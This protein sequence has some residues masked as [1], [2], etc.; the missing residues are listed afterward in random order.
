MILT[1]TLNPAIDLTYTLPAITLG[2]SHRVPEP[3]Q[4]AGGKGV[5]VARVL[6]EQ[7]QEAMVLAPVGGPTG[8]QF[9]TDLDAAG[10]PHRLIDVTAP[11][12]RTIT[13]VTDENATALNEAGTAPSAAE[14]NDLRGTLASALSRA[15]VLVCSGSVPAG[16]PPD[17][18]PQ[19][20]AMAK[21][22]GVPVIV[23][24]SGPPLLAAADA[25][26]DVLKPNADEL[27]QAAA[28]AFAGSGPAAP[29]AG[30]DAESDDDETAAAVSA[31]PEKADAER[32]DPE[33]DDVG[34]AQR[35]P[36][37]AGSPEAA[38]RA[39]RGL[40]A[41][42]GGVVFASLGADGMV[43]VGQSGPVWHA[44]LP[45]PLQGNPTGAGDAAV[46]AIAL[47]LSRHSAAVLDAEPN[48][49]RQTL[50]TATG[51][52]AAAVLTPNAGSI[53]D[54]DP[55][56]DQVILTQVQT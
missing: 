42:S 16:S 44:R 45:A 39:A 28:G 36:G 38:V 32:D 33:R 50:H 12:R 29:A 17:L 51:W 49:L 41:R 18:I 34:P 25:G 8:E 24:T 7:G 23:D 22:A 19:V 15:T 26:A 46:A 2:A 40:A 10:L 27:A 9:R 52:S 3:L 5:N 43:A 47:C 11:T 35:Q 48:T 4:R 1:L 55:L 53:A 30:P 21:D 14:L 20:V 37:S 13:L 56:L 6:A 54:P 31:D